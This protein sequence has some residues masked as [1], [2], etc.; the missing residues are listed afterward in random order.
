MIGSDRR[1]LDDG[2][3]AAGA[4]R[5]LRGHQLPGRAHRRAAVGARRHRPGR[6]TRWWCSPSDHGEM[7]GERGLWYKMTFF[8]PSARVPLIV[9]GPGVAPGR[10]S[11]LRVAAR[12]GADAG[13]AGRGRRRRRRRLR[14]QPAWPG[15][16]RVATPGPTWRLGEY[17]AEGVRTPEVMMRRGRHKYLHARGDPDRLYD[18]E[19]DPLRAR[20]SGRAPEHAELAGRVP[21]RGGT[22]VGSRSSSSGRCSTASGGGGWWP[23]RSPAA[24]TRPWDFQPH[25]DASLQWVRGDAAANPRPSQLRPR[26]GLPEE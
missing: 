15:C 26:G 1:P 3:A 6:A 13:G 10:A 11:R 17:L 12:P 4:A 24:R 8:D 25:T 18:L 19:A 22:A 21:R 23:R 16:W 14:R 20:Q 5:L 2:G 7:L 9:R